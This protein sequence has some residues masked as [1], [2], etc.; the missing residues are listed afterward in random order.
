MRMLVL[1]IPLFASYPTLAQETFDCVL[2]PSAVVKVGSPMPG[3]LSDVMAQRGTTVRAGQPI[4]R[5]ES[6]TEVA[7]VAVN[8]A[9]ANSRAAIIAQEA[10]VD[11]SRRRL[12]R[13]SRLA[14]NNIVT[15]RDLETQQAELA[16]ARQELARAVEQ[17]DIARLELERAKIILALR[18][19]TSPL[20]G[21]VTERALRGGEYVN[22]DGHILTI[23]ALNPL[24]VETFLPVRYY[25]TITIGDVAVV[26]TDAPLKGT[27]EA[28]VAV[29]DRVFDAAS[30]TF[31]VR[32][33]LDNPNAS[34]PAGLRCKVGF[35]P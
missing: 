4:A 17:R 5:L 15:E 26:E 27:H 34:L 18:T 25:G 13:L 21:V 3:L 6:S 12:E 31:G 30:S 33:T 19:I 7:T 16:I 14:S 9:Q 22:Q 23:A 2:D 29:I 1:A 24:Y 28:R 32:L 11:L 35:G 10:R 20:D 8:E